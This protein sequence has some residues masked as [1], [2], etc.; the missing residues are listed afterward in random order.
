[1]NYLLKHII[2]FIVIILVQVF[3]MDRI[4]PLHQYVIPYLYFIYI[5]WLPFNFSTASL[6]LI[7][8]SFGFTLDLFTKTPGLHAAVCTLVAFMRP[9]VI[10]LLM[11]REATETGY[12]EPSIKS[13]SFFPYAV[14][15][16]IL[17]LFHHVFL[18]FLE[19]LHFGNFFYFVGKVLASS[20][21]SLFLILLVEMLFPRRERYRTNVA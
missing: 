17:T 20:A 5:L 13:M 4:P 15:V 19:W 8:F 21:L 6:L 12:T 7:G 2:R 18:V 9:A 14:Y 3:I 11:L 1:M 16:I 10:S